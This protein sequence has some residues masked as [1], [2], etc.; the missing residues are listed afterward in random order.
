MDLILFV[1]IFSVALALTQALFFLVESQFKPEVRRLKRQIGVLSEDRDSASG[2]NI[3]KKRT[4]SQIPWFNEILINLKAPTIFRIERLHRQADVKQPL[5]VFILLSVIAPVI[6]FY[7]IFILS[8][9]TVAALL[10][11]GLAAP[12]PWVFLAVRKKRRFRALERQL[13]DALDMIARSLKA[14][15]ALTG[16]FQM[17]AMEFADPARAEFRKTLD[18]INFG[19]SY[20]EAL[21]NMTERFDSPDLK[22]FVLS[23]I[24]QRQSGGNL[25]EILEKISSLIRE[26]FKLYGKV[27]SLTGEA[28]V[29]AVILTTLPFLVAAALYFA[30][31]AYIDILFR[32]QVGQIMVGGAVVMMI[33]GILVMSRMIKIEV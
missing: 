30:N 22:F 23:V 16:G 27:R 1:G 9:S 15:H 12:L 4:L 8:R 29:S 28:R 14:G 19:L 3:V 32:E 11:A 7:L 33:L 18:E 17:V 26:R 6:V 20:E 31:R 21:R 24:I 2:V 13:P 5:G 10:A 25:A